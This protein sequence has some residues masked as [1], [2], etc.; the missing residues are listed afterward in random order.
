MVYYF[1]KFIIDLK[2]IHLWSLFYREG[3]VGFM[4]GIGLILLV[5][6]IHKLITGVF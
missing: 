5:W 1:K 2:K 6:Q 3:I 4:I